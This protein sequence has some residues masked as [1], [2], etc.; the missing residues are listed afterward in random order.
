ME[1][2]LEVFQFMGVPSMTKVSHESI[3]VQGYYQWRTAE[4]IQIQVNSL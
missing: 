4:E 1:M 3:H 2:G